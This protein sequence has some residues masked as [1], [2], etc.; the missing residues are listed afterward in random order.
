MFNFV[1]ACNWIVIRLFELESLNF[2][3]GRGFL[4]GVFLYFRDP[5]AVDGGVT[6]SIDQILDILIAHTLC[7][8]RFYDPLFF[9]C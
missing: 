1:K 2:S 3:L 5:D 9:W 7:D 8:Q 6:A 4:A